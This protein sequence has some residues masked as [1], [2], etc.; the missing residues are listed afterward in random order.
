MRASGVGQIF[1]CEGHMGSIKYLNILEYH[2]CRLLHTSLFDDTN[3]D[4]V[5]FQEDN[6]TCHK[7]LRTMTWLRENGIELV[8]WH[9]QSPDLNS[10]E[11]LRSLLKCKVKIVK[12]P[13]APTVEMCESLRL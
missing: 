10:I 4:G 1:V 7:A 6:A 5:K 3:M 13:L 11:H 9:A 2:Y 12:Q 8:N